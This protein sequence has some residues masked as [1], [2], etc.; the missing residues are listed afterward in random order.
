[1]RTRSVSALI[2]TALTVLVIGS[3]TADALVATAPGAQAATSLS[4]TVLHKGGLQ[5]NSHC[6][7]LPCLR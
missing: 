6:F 7:K 3:G 4:A 5:P 2:A 1:M